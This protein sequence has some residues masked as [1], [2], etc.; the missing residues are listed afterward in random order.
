M[1]IRSGRWHAEIH[2]R[3]LWITRG[4]DPGCPNCQGTGG[5]WRGNS[6]RADWDECACLDQIRA[7]RLPLWRC[8]PETEPE[9][10]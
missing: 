8:R 2:H 3:S 9:P 4:P 5:G 7:W 1:P 10:F 6:Q